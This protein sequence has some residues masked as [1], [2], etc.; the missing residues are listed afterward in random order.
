MFQPGDLVVYGTT[1]VCRVETISTPNS[2]GPDRHKQYYQLNPLYQDGFIYA[3]VDGI[4][5]PVRAV[6]TREEAEE[7]IDQIPHIQAE[8]YR[9]PT[10]QALAQY[11]QSA[12]RNCNCR[13]MLELIMSIYAKQRQAEARKRRLGMVDERY[14][15][16][17][18][19][20]LHGELAVALDIPYE[21][22][23]P[24]I[25]QRLAAMKQN[26]A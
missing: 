15:K 8:A 23:E 2:R 10:M 12:I 1:G 4:K 9:A 17:A 13:S 26:D 18:T 19:R 25:A 16:Q 20:L 21:Q 22:V 7:L 6:T 24:Y 14:M 3:P 5:V 11:Y